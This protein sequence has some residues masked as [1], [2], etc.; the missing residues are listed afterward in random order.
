MANPPAAHIGR[1]HT[2]QSL[3]KTWTAGRSSRRVWVAFIDWAKTTKDKDGKPLLPDPVEIAAKHLDTLTKKDVAIMRDIL[4]ADAVEEEKAKKEN[5]PAVLMADRYKPAANDMLAR[6]QEQALLYQDIHSPGVQSV[7]QSVIG[8][9]YFVLLLLQKNH[10][11]L[12]TVEEVM[13]ILDGMPQLEVNKLIGITTG[14]FKG[15]E[16]N[17][18]APAA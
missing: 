9:S 13:D 11:E 8:T 2:F 18:E 10:K 14:T 16:K 1:E 12:Q 4:I 6:A 7:F 3:G 15:T 17:G 5:R